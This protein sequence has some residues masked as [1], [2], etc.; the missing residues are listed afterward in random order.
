MPPPCFIPIWVKIAVAIA[1]GLGTMVGW[2]RI[3]V[4][5]GEKIGKTHLTYAQGASAELVAAATI[6]AA[7]V[8]GSAG[9]D[10][11]RPVVGRSRHDGRQPFRAADG[12][13]PQHVDGVGSDPPGGDPPVGQPVLGLCQSV[14]RREATRQRRLRD[15]HESENRSAA[16]TGRVDRGVPYIRIE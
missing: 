5:V 4:T 15:A 16:C 14:L 13:R 7:D 11:A 10:D 3:V 8:F 2:K 1:L 12:H 6:A 9:L